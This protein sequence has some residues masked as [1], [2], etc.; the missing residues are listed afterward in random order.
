MFLGVG[1]VKDD[2][3]MERREGDI[4]YI[5]KQVKMIAINRMVFMI[6]LCFVVSILTVSGAYPLICKYHNPAEC[7]ALES[8]DCIGYLK[9]GPW[10]CVLGY[11]VLYWK[12]IT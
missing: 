3:G 9:F 2:L 5:S 8:M 4:L 6:V 10:D 1:E 11:Y 7:R 12:A